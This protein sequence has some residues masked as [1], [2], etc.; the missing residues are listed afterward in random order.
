MP[1][2]YS[3]NF[4][5]RTQTSVPTP[6]DALLSPERLLVIVN[7]RLW[8]N[9]PRRKQ[10]APGA[11]ASVL[12]PP[13]LRPGWRDIPAAQTTRRPSAP[14]PSTRAPLPRGLRP[15]PQDPRRHPASTRADPHP[16]V[17]QETATLPCRRPPRNEYRTRCKG[18]HSSPG[19]RTNLAGFRENTTRSDRADG[20]PRESSSR[21]GPRRRTRSGTLENK[22]KL[23]TPCAKGVA[24][25]GSRRNQEASGPPGFYR[26][27][28]GNTLPQPLRRFCR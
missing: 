20:V 8:P 13:L 7:R 11:A 16:P 12:L 24:A 9:R 14:R 23:Q 25:A 22:A 2:P 19:T 15:A 4:R 26:W 27:A 5:A 17:H 21:H 28:N 10:R 18:P 6:P 1:P 3:D